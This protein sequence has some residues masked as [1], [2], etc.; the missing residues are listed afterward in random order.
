M[1]E[2][3]ANSPAFVWGLNAIPIE[4]NSTTGAVGAIRE[5]WKIYLNHMTK[6]TEEPGWNMERTRLLV[7]LLQ[8]M[9]KHLGYDVS[10]VEIETGIYAPRG[11][12]QAND[13]QEVIRQG[14][15]KILRG[16]ESLSMAVKSMPAD[17]EMVA[18]WRGVLGGLN[19]FLAA[20]RNRRSPGVGQAPLAEGQTPQQP[21]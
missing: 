18:L 1:I 15:A 3:G 13:D 12:M 9:G 17:P 5:A 6:N 10:R 2:R 21:R 8:A 16:E 11:H 14:V 20:D 4:F 19:E 7:D